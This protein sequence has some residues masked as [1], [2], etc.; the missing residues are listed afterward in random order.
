MKPLCWAKWIETTLMYPLHS[1]APAIAF[2]CVIERWEIIVERNFITFFN[3]F[4]RKQCYSWKPIN[5]PFFHFG[6]RCARMVN[7]PSKIS[8]SMRIDQSVLI[9]FHTIL[10]NI[11]FIVLY[12][13]SHIPN[14]SHPRKRHYEFIR[15][16]LYLKESSYLFWIK[17]NMEQ[18]QKCENS[19]SVFFLNRWGNEQ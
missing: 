8:H 4:F 10:M 18:S 13:G 3:I 6:I 7:E 11:N 17:K 15:T 9:Y 16:L 1:C 12:P 19:D 14:D 5:D 2:L